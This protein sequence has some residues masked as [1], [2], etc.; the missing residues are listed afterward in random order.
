MIATFQTTR[1]WNAPGSQPEFL[2]KTEMMREVLAY[3]SVSI[4]KWAAAGNV[5]LKAGA[6]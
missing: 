4:V 5:T 3:R 2:S 6:N 1:R